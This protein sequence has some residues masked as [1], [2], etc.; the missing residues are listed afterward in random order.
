MGVNSTTINKPH[1]SSQPDVELQA[2]LLGI[3]LISTT[4]TNSIWLKLVLTAAILLVFLPLLY[5]G[6]IGTVG[7]NR[8]GIILNFCAGLMV[9]PELLGTRILHWIET[10][11]SSAKTYSTEKN[12]KL[13]QFG[14]IKVPSIAYYAFIATGI[15][16][17]LNLTIRAYYWFDRSTNAAITTFMVISVLFYALFQ[18]VFPS[19]LKRN[20]LL[21]KKYGDKARYWHDPYGLLLLIMSFPY[22]SLV[23]FS[24]IYI[25]W[26]IVRLVEEITRDK[27]S[28]AVL[29][30]LGVLFFIVGNFLQFIATF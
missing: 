11:Y 15:Y 10:N 13:T 8:I 25:L 26:P 23:S 5:F 29:V 27:H 18:L 2:K 1:K 22:L 7:V 4:D 20:E 30:G 19:L 9:A 16:L 17:Y 28:R 6:Y 3:T 21:T 14:V 24:A 12:D